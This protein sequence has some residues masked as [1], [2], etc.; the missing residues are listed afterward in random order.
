MLVE[1]KNRLIK[2]YIIAVI[3]LLIFFHYLGV[4]RIF[5]DNFFNVMGMAQ[6]NTFNFLTKLKYSFINYQDAQNLKKENT[7]LKEQLNQLNYD[8]SQ[9]KAYQVENEKLRTILNFKEDK[10]YNTVLAAVIGKDTNKA[11]SLIIN[12]GFQDGVRDGFAVVVDRGIIIGKIIDTKD[13]MSTVLLL[14]DKMS[15]LAISLESS[16]KTN[17]LAEGEYGLSLKV[18][19]IP[20]DILINEGDFIITSGTEANIPRGLLIGKINRIISQ[21]SELFQSATIN[22]LI[23]Y[24]EISIV[25]VIIPNQ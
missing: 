9:L 2:F 7:E 11:N 13:Y 16:N 19:Y 1:R 20:Q 15:Q 17:G 18:N 14:N 23:A 5:E 12:K 3:I 25:A 6:G 22:P 10:N 8:N 24:N 4:L 21:G